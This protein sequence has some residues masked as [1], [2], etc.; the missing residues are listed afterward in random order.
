[1]PVSGDN[2]E[3]EGANDVKDLSRRIVGFAYLEFE[4][5]PM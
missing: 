2:C 4:V 5:C 3:S 1:M